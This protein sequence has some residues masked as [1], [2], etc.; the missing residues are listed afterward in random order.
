MIGR[1]CNLCKATS[2]NLTITNVD[3]CGVCDCDPTGTMMGD[4]VQPQE[5]ICDQNS[6]QCT[7]L[8]YREGRRCDDCS[9][10]K[11]NHLTI[12]YVKFVLLIYK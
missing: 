7:C 12:L 11:Y 9:T 6:G 2:Y 4:Q 3:G 8:A 10:G 1:T 5:L